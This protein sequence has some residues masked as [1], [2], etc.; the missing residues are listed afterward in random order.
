MA[1]RELDE[2]V[3]LMHG[4]EFWVGREELVERGVGASGRAHGVVVAG[5]EDD[6]WV[7]GCFGGEGGE[8]GELVGDVGA[9]ELCLRRHGDDGVVEDEPLGDE[10]GG[11]VGGGAVAVAEGVGLVA[12]LEGEEARAEDAMGGG[13]FG[14]GVL[15]GALAEVEA[16]EAG[17]VGGVEEGAEVAQGEGGGGGSGL[18]GVRWCR[19]RRPRRAA[20]WLGRRRSR[21]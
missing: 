13:G 11:G 7:L 2:E 5:Q 9:G 15:F 1:A 16:V 4:G 6:V 21:W 8:V 12:D 14:D 20:G 19:G 17:P 18:D 3:A 10:V